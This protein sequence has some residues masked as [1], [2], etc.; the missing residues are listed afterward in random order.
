MVAV[1]PITGVVHK[2]GCYW[3][4]QCVEKNNIIKLDRYRLMRSNEV[5]ATAPRCVHCN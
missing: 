2:W 1:N 3:L 4:E 5:S